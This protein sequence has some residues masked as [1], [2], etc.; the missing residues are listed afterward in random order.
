MICPKCGRDIPDG[1]QCPCGAP[2][3]SSNP[4][5]NLIKTLGS[6]PKFLSVAVLSTVS[7]VLGFLGSLSLNNMLKEVFATSAQLNGDVE[8]MAAMEAVFAFL[9]SSMILFVILGSLPMILFIVGM[10]MFYAS[11]RSKVTGNVSTTGLTVCKV[12]A[13][14]ALVCYCLL[15]ALLVLLVVL[16]IIA[17]AAGTMSSSNYGDVGAEGIA[18]L[19]VVFIFFLVVAGGLVALA[20]AYQVGIIRFINR[21]KASAATGVPD[22]RVSRFLTGFMMV[23]G[24]LSVVGSLGSLVTSPLSCLGSLASA[25]AMIV[26]SLLLSEYRNKMTMLLYPP[27][28]PVYGPYGSVPP[29]QPGGPEGGFPQQ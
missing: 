16:W 12:P 26:M 22:N 15:G 13:Y 24:I 10:W 29:Q 14:L 21:V 2:L 3:L 9:D 25:A 5:V 20:I 17:F 7:I 27:V 1:T 8:L 23:L 4:T 28:Q 11:S 19:L 18:F 6:S